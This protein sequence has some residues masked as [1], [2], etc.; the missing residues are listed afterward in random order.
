MTKHK[1]TKYSLYSPKQLH[2]L[3]IDIEKYPEFLP[4]CSAARILKQENRFIYG[5]LVV[6]FKSFHGKYVS[7]IE[8]LMPN[9]D[10]DRYSINVS[11]VEGP[12][13]YLTN[14]WYF[15]NDKQLNKTKITFEID[16]CFTSTI[17]Q[18]LVGVVFER[19]LVTM[20]SAFEQRAVIVY[21]NNN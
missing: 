13:K 16:F 1:E 14:L 9:A 17:L 10:D 5:E 6:S 4:W 20:M 7:K 12:F 15:E 2:D 8:S 11:L 19:A 21:G 3:V 18:S